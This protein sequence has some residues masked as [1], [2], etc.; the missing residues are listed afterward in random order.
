MIK[1]LRTIILI[2]PIITFAQQTKVEVAGGNSFLISIDNFQPKYVDKQIDNFIIRDYVQFTNP[3]EELSYKLPY[4]DIYLAIPPESK[5]KI[6]EL[7]FAT[8]IQNKIIPELN[9]SVVVKDSG[10]AY[11]QNDPLKFVRDEVQKNPVGVIGYFY[12]R[13]FYIAHLRINNYTFNRENSSVEILKNIKLKIDLSNSVNILAYSPIQIKTDFDKAISNLIANPNIAEQFRSAVSYSLPDTTGNWIDYNSTYLKLGVGKDGVYR[14]TKS[15]LLLS[16]VPVTTVDPRTFKLFESGKEIKIFVKGQDDGS[17]DDNDFME[18]WGHKNYPAISH[19]IINGDNQE[20]NEYL[21]RYTDSTFYFLTWNQGN[22][23]RPDTIDVGTIGITD[24]II[25]FSKLL[26]SEVNQYFDFNNIDEIANQTPNWNK[27]K[28]WYQHT[29]ITSRTYNFLLDEIYPNKNANVFAKTVSWASSIPTNSHQVRLLINNVFIDSNSVDRFKQLLLTGEIYSLNLLNGSNQ[30]KLENIPNGSSPNG[31]LTDWLEIEY[32]RNLKLLNDSLYFK[33]SNDVSAGLKILKIGNATQ[34]SYRIYKVKPDFQIINNYNVSSSNL[35]FADTVSPGD[36]YYVISGER[37]IAPKFYYVKNFG[38]LRSI[39]KQTDYISITHPKFL[40]AAQNYVQSIAG[41]Y[42]LSTSAYN[43]QDIFDEFAFGYPY[44]EAIRLFANVL[45]NNV[46]TP[47]PS[48][49]TLIGDANYDYKYFLGTG[50][51]KNYVPSYGNPVGDNWFAVWD[52]N[53]IPVPQLKV[54]RIPINETTE[55][56]YYLTKIQNN[57][58]KPFDEWNKKYILFSGGRSDVPG[59]LEYLKSANDAIVTN[60]IKPMPISGNYTHFYKTRNPQTDFG[61]YTPEE[62]SNVISDGGLFISYI[63]H[64]GTATW[65][66]SINS[67]NQLYNKVNRN[68]LITDFGCS[69]N[70]YAEPNIICFGERFLFNSTGQAL[71]YVGNSSLGF[72]STAVTAPVSFYEEIF[73]DS[74]S[75]VGNASLFSKIKLLTQNGNTSVNKIFVLTN[76]ILGDPAVR[77][78]VPKL[79]NFKITSADIIINEQPL[80]ESEDSVQF[81]IALKNLGL[82]QSGNLEIKLGQTFDGNEIKNELKTIL[83]PEYSDT[84]DVWVLTKNKPGDHSLN[85]QIDPNNLLEEIYENDNSINFQFSVYSSSLRDLLTSQTEI[86]GISKIE[87]LNPVNYNSDSISIE[88]QLSQTFDFSNPITITTN[89]DTFSTNITFPQLLPDSRYYIR[90]KIDSPTTFFSGTKSFYNKP[91]YKY[92]LI[93]SLSFSKLNRN[94][95]GSKNDSL[96]ILLDTTKISVLSAG[97]N[98]GATCVIAKDGV[99]LLSNTYFAGMGIVVFDNVTLQVDTSTWFNLFNQPANVEALATLIDSIP[100]GKIVAIGVADDAR[101]NLSTHLKNSIKSLGSSKID[102]LQFRGSWALIGWKGAPTGSVLEGVEAP[103]PPESVFLE[104]QYVFIADSGSFETSAIGKASLWKN[105][106]V[107][108]SLPA[109]AS[110]KYLL[111]GKNVNGQFDFLR[112]L[113]FTNGISDINDI[114]S[115]IYPQI[116]IQGKLYASS[117]KVSPILNKLAVDFRSVAELG[118]NYQVVQVS[119]DTINQ[120]KSNDLFF[121]IYNL[122]ET[123]ADSFNVLVE[124]VKPNNTTKLLYDTLVTRLDTA[125][126]LAFKY[127]Y[128][129]NLYDGYGNLKFRISIDPASRIEEF[130]KD[131]NIFEKSFFVIQDTT[132]TSVTESTILITFDGIEIFDGDFVGK[133]PEI[134]INL[135]YP[136]WFPVSDTSSIRFFLDGVEYYS[137]DIINSYDTVNRI[138]TY[139][140]TPDLENGEHILKIIGRDRFGNMDPNASVER[141]F[142]VD[143]KLNLIDVYNYPNPFSDQTYFTFKLSQIPDELEIKIF[144]ISG[145]F[146]KSIKR[147]NTQ[148]NF[149]FNRINW[150]GRDEDGD[151]VASGVYLYKMILRKSGEAI[152]VTQKLAV[153]R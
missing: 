34:S 121:D 97:Y 72:Q 38:N 9:P 16:G 69:T 108:E 146:V 107:E 149:D 19:R 100:Y 21:N 150:D 24:T 84:I 70:K 64:S 116:K 58:A 114:D 101:N 62:F 22:G 86:S 66:N 102:S 54:G 115:K 92:L 79:P 59:E 105:V 123:A 23:K 85:V 88:F 39:N 81:K 48:F 10:I 87:L 2:L 118:T 139:K 124:L 15:F 26:H 83:I 29:L 28:T 78:K 68:P 20:Y 103:L 127:H 44:P 148:L 141:I 143:D 6:S 37:N 132:P 129:S 89:A 47:K 27:N 76:L 73:N 18:F 119:P 12:Y 61:P 8:E 130:Y 96:Q 77:L 55:L 133:N 56:D 93:D 82:S 152:S 42:N 153:V 90:Y 136:V 98:A 135:Q 99:N 25:Y 140:M 128:L 43:V 110:T 33:I 95:V 74:L 51:G 45:Y 122:G 109:D 5:I 113:L 151:L 104:S 41:L 49:L 106:L 57:E 1:Y 111:F 117:S 142:A 145:R 67:T 50:G 30:I 120:G 75:E 35:F 13:D 112:T 144:T 36:E 138:A 46:Q 147:N 7:N 125:M 4:L 52:P 32:P 134:L 60:Y 80:N 65:D 40:S 91:D 17:F 126:H 11:L 137:S 94:N 63:G 71:A 3:S 53:A 131:N 31:L 14:I